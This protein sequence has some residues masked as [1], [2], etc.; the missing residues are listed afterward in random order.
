[1]KLC[2]NKFNNQEKTDKFLEM[3]KLPRLNQ[4]QIDNSTEQLLE[5]KLNF[6]K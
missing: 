5:V 1:M 4:D 6:K 2:I 3:Y